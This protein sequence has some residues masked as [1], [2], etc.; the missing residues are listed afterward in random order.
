MRSRKLGYVVSLVAVTILAVSPTLLEA[1]SGKQKGPVC[2]LDGTW[3][4]PEFYHSGLGLDF[5]STASYTSGSFWHGTLNMVWIARLAEWG[6]ITHGI[7][8][9]VSGT[10]PTGVW[11]RTG[12]RTFEYTVVTFALDELGAPVGKTVNSGRLTVAKGCNSLEVLA[13]GDF[14]VP[15]PSAEEPWV[16]ASSVFFPDGHAHFAP[17]VYQRMKVEPV[18]EEE[19]PAP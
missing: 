5:G 10:D 6:F 19:H 15:G 16:R 4:G 17:M 14:F 2:R 12:R 1:G 7:T 13:V 8:T 9:A 3:M 18:C 11:K